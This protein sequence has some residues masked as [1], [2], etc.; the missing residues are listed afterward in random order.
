MRMP[1]CHRRPLTP[2]T[3][4]MPRSWFRLARF[5]LGRL[6]AVGI[7]AVIAVS[8][9]NVAA[10]DSLDTGV[11]THAIIF[12]VGYDVSLDR[13]FAAVVQHYSPAPPFPDARFL[14]TRF[15]PPPETTIPPL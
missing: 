6:R 7:D 3:A 10:E 13:A 12:I 15:P 11:N 5:R 1:C 9:R 2:V 4:S 14:S 8:V